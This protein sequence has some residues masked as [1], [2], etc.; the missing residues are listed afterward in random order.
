MTEAQY[1]YVFSPNTKAHFLVAKAAWERLKND[2]RF[3]LMRSLAAGELEIKN[4]ALYNSSK[5]AVLHM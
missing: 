2:G 1:D 5:L 4:H 3:V